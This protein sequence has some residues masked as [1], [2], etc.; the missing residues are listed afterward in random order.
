MN[1]HKKKKADLIQELVQL[2]QELAQ[3]KA[4]RNSI[5]QETVRQR[6]LLSTVID[7]MPV[8]VL[9]DITERKKIGDQL[10]LLIAAVEQS[11]NTIVI[12]NIQGYIEYVNPSFERM[13]GY[14][15]AEALGCHTRLLKSGYTKPEEYKE[16][17][18]TITSGNTWQGEFYNKKK[19]GEYYW[20][21][22][23]I[24]PIHNE[25]EEIT[26]FLAVKED[27]TERK[28][29]ED[30]L[31]KQASE[32]AMVAQV[33]A[34]SS[35][36]L[37]TDTLLQTTLD[38]I[39]EE[40]V[41][42]WQV[43]VYL[44]DEVESVLKLVAGT[45]ER[46]Q[47]LVDQD[48]NIPFNHPTSIVVQ[49]ARDQQS[50]IVNDISKMSDQIPPSLSKVRSQLAVPMIARGQLLGVLDFQSH[51]VDCFSDEDAKIKTTLA[52][53]IAVALQNANQFEHSRRQAERERLV[54][55]ISQK[56]QNTVTINGALQVAVKELGQSFRARSTRVQLE[57]DSK[58]LVDAK[59]QEQ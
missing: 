34:A 12:T 49:V 35:N 27:I 51:K 26:H 13:T 38:L 16:L 42:L 47:I 18:Q 1:D 21:L 40:Q 57:R 39:K 7:A 46:E 6:E 8:N 11:A 24:S 50:V 48:W 22:A 3:L 36:L 37:D 44:L 19:N 56:I 4:E 2:R 10:R 9:E 32:L 41:D 43:D 30:R 53:Q 33:A 28:K 45:G 58:M 54:N 29:T 23:S 25:Q 31:V 17:W 59:S 14:T 5:E 15:S 55:T 20:E 52:S